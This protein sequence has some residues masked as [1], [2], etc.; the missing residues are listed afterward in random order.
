MKETVPTPNNEQ[1]PGLPEER[2]K[3]MTTALFEQMESIDLGAGSHS[4]A[5]LAQDC[6]WRGKEPKLWAKIVSEITETEASEKYPEFSWTQFRTLKMML[7]RER[8]FED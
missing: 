6:D 5:N 3:E 4:L 2:F 7:D 1:E 8:S